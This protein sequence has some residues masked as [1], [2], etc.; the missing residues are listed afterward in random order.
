MKLIVEE[1][2]A[3]LRVDKYLSLKLKKSR[4]FIQKLI[5]M[6]NVRLNSLTDLKSS[7]KIVS[8]D[9]IEVTIPPPVPISLKPENI[10]L[11]IIY[12]DKDIVV[13]NKPRG[14]LVHPVSN[15][16]TGTL[17]NALCYH[18][19]DLSGIGGVLRPGIVHRLD[20]FTSGVMVV[21]K[22]DKTHILLSE[23][24]KKRQVKKTYIAVVKGVVEIE[25]AEIKIPLSRDSKIRNRRKPD[26]KG[27]MAITEFAVMER[28]KKH[29]IL[30]LNLKT[31]RTHQ[32]RVHLS[33][34]GHPVVGD[35]QY[36]SD[37]KNYPISGQALHSYS[38]EFELYNRKLKFKAEIPEDMKKLIERLK[39]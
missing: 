32:I 9:I 4:T 10:P 19:K 16:V 13:I 27:K 25:K 38:I 17:V 1:S 20:R 23:L 31:G 8:G 2:N 15:I 6:G 18:I 28:L 35:T 7:Y 26:L 21:A 36:S 3:G 37:Y 24:F 33:Y 22:N 11:Q 30:K 34:I 29:T 39:V 14:M 12:E 5:D